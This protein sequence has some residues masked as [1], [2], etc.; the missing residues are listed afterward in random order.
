MKSI[1]TIL[2][3]LTAF[4]A[5]FVQSACDITRQLLGAQVELLPP[6]MVYAA[7][8]GNLASVALLAACGGLWLDSLSA[9]PPGASV[10]PLFAVG[11]ALHLKRSVILREQFTARLVLGVAA[12]AGVPVLT[13]LL[14]LSMGWQPLL[15]WGSVWQLAVVSLG[16]GILTPAV[17]GYFEL[18]N[19]VFAYRPVTQTSF[20]PDREILRGRR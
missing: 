4:V 12:G 16:G 2:L 11:L 1:H 6:L 14:L 13:V 19:R 5:V 20:R 18:L 10:L 7:L 8:T 9:N 17:F 15:G 3:L